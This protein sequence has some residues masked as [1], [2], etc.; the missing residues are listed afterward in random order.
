MRIRLAAAAT[1]SW[2][3]EGNEHSFERSSVHA[4]ADAVAVACV[5]PVSSNDQLPLA[6]LEPLTCDGE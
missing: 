1:V 4:H 6:Y 2:L 5:Q 3:Q